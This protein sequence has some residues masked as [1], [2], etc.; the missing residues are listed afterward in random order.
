MIILIWIRK[1]YKALASD[2]S[3]SSIAFAFLFGL[4]L[5]FVPIVS[6][7]GFFLI[8]LLLIFRVQISSALMALGI[9]K[10]ISLAGASALF[11]PVGYNLLETEALKPFWKWFLNL[12][13]IAWLGLD[14]YGILGGAL[15]GFALGAILFFPIR[16]LIIGYRRYIHER[17]SKN[18]FFKWLTSF[19][20][21]KGLRFIFIGTGVNA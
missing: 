21:V 10:L 19:W 9:G 2:A 14:V 15:L 17:V 7:L 16:Q 8:A 13:V 3:P 5:G 12:P 4:T 1:I 20:L 6:G 18:K 11:V